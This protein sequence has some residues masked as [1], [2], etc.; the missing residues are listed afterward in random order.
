M[1]LLLLINVTVNVDCFFNA[2]ADGIC[3]QSLYCYLDFSLLI[4]SWG[5]G[6]GWRGVLQTGHRDVT[7][8]PPPQLLFTQFL[9]IVVEVAALLF[10][11]SSKTC[12][13]RNQCRAH[14]M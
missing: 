12:G 8:L 11:T 14:S 10:A 6:A 1:L 9:T 5:G 2:L 13:W 3:R 7:F 4:F